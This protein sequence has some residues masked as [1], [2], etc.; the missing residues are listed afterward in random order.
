MTYSVESDF[1]VVTI[2][3]EQGKH[4]DPIRMSNFLI[5]LME[6][7]LPNIPQTPVGTPE[8]VFSGGFDVQVYPNPATEHLVIEANSGSPVEAS[9]F[10]ASGVL[11]LT[12]VDADGR[13]EL[14]RDRLGSGLFLATIR[15]QA[16]GATVHKRVVFR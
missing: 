6:S 13:I 8:V 5:D 3:I 4:L 16:S 14:R 11:V 1:S 15:E 2:V 7:E 12:A 10:N 9:V